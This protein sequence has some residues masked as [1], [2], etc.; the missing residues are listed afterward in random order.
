MIHLK[1]LAICSSLL[2][3]VLLTGAVAG[4]PR[5]LLRQQM[6]WTTALGT[7][8]LLPTPD[9][10]IASVLWAISANGDSSVGV[11]WTKRLPSYVKEAYHMGYMTEDPTRVYRAFGFPTTARGI[12]DAGDVVGAYQD[13]TAAG[14]PHHGYLLHGGTYY[15]MDVPWPTATETNTMGMSNSGSIVGVWRVGE[16]RHQYFYT[17]GVFT[18]FDLP[19]EFNSCNTQSLAINSHGIVS[20]TYQQTRPLLPCGG[21]WRGYIR[22]ADGSF[23]A[24]D[25]TADAGSTRV[26][27]MND[28]G[29]IVGHY[30]TADGETH[31]FMMPG[32]GEPVITIDF[33]HQIGTR[34]TEAHGIDGTGRVIVGNAGLPNYSGTGPLAR[35]FKLTLCG[36]EC[37]AAR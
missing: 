28:R 26:W 29:D 32:D 15:N 2:A 23:T 17:D 20:G 14:N 18:A 21:P 34:Y 27:G 12:N 5:A 37:G 13:T 4:T 25:A 9:D 30:D 1:P 3:T 35:P 36:D 31:G 19:D 24:F 16:G 11:T 8:T 7:F 6:K 10:S 22:S 33:P